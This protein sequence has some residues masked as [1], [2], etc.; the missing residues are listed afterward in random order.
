MPSVNN[1]RRRG[2]ALG[3]RKLPRG[4]NIPAA[5]LPDSGTSATS[6]LTGADVRR[7]NRQARQTARQAAL[8]SRYNTAINRGEASL[9]TSQQAPVDYST[10][11]APPTDSSQYVLPNLPTLPGITQAA[12]R[13]E[14]NKQKKL[15]KAIN[16]LNKF[17]EIRNKEQASL[18]LGLDT[19]ADYSNIQPGGQAGMI[20]DPVTGQPMDFSQQYQQQYQ[21]QYPLYP[22]APAPSMAPDPYYPPPDYIYPST[23]YEP[24]VPPMATQSPLGSPIFSSQ[25]GAEGG[26]VDPA[27][28]AYDP[29]LYDGSGEPLP[30]DLPNMTPEGDLLFMEPDD[31]LIGDASMNERFAEFA[32]FEPLDSYAA[33]SAEPSQANFSSLL[34]GLVQAGAQAYTTNRTASAD[35]RAKQLAAQQAARQAAANK[36][37]KGGVSPLVLIGGI[38]LVLVVG[39]LALRSRK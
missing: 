39:G 35:A 7:A 22:G 33:F 9:A 18:A 29:S 37:A 27:L 10:I 19:P 17:N 21:Q 26:Y 5:S 36:K 8:L 6:I 30:F 3:I 1:L 38:A 13:R 4:V 20:T 14:K 25:L 2:R 15:E 12:I 24:Y 32:D 23:G 16:K 31:S 34:T 11:V 28:I